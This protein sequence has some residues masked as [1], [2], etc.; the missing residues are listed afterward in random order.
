MN[1]KLKPCP[2][3]AIEK[4]SVEG[5]ANNRYMV[6]VCHNCGALVSGHRE[7]LLGKWNTRKYI[8]RTCNILDAA[9]SH[10]VKVL[11]DSE[12]RGLNVS[13]EDEKPQHTDT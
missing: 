12:Y 1:I 2:F 9:D 8:D 11:K 7:V 4:L 5:D 10:A 6:V 13:F 3:C